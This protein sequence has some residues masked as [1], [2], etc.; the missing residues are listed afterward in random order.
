M[1]KESFS[2]RNGFNKVTEAPIIVRND[3]PHD[4]RGVIPEL[5]YEYGFNP[6]N[7]RELVCRQLRKRPDQNNWSREPVKKEVL[8]HLDNCP[9]F[10]VYDILEDIASQLQRI[11]LENA[12]E[13]FQ[14]DINDYLIAQGIG[15]KL[16]DSIVT[17]RGPEGLDK[18]LT[19]A[20]ATEISQGHRTA[21]RK[22]VV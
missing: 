12:P 7:L 11:S 16:V 15:W 10:K 20:V 19:L 13:D 18:L 8:D 1:R 5:A 4:F 6:D 14:T 9:W 22:S 2:K 21:D 17:Y 3:A